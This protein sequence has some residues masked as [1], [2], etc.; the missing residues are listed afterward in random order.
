MKQLLL[1]LTATLVLTVAHGQTSFHTRYGSISHDKAN[2]VIQTQDGNFLVAG[3]TLGFGSS[4]N[5]FMMK[6]NASGAILWTKDYSGVNFDE[7]IDL[8]ELPGKELVMCG[9]TGSYGAGQTD[10]FVMKT[11]SLG[12]L[13]WSKSYGGF[14]QES[15]SKIST[16]GSGGFYIAGSGYTSFAFS[17]IIRLDSSGAII[18]SQVVNDFAG[19]VAMTPLASGGVILALT[20]NIGNQGF[21]L[22]KFSL[23]GALIWSNNYYP[24]PM[25]VGLSGGGFSIIEN[26]S[27][28]ILVNY[29]AS[30]TNTVAQASDNFVT[31]LN[32]NGTV[33]WN[34]SYGGT[35]SDYCKT[36]ANTNDG[37]IILFGM[38]NSAGNGD[39]DVC[40]I[41]LQSNGSFQWAK[42]YGTAW[43]DKISNGIQTADN[44][45]IFT[46]QTWTVG[47]AND[48]SKIHLVKTDALGNTS[49]NDISWNVTTINQAV[50]I[51]TASA[52]SN[53][54]LMDNPINWNFNN[55][56]LYTADICHYL[57]AES[58]SMNADN[59]RIYPNPFS[60]QTTFET[61][62]FL[63]NATLTLH[64]SFGQT[65]K[66][67]QNI[68]GQTVTLLRENLPSGL[69]FVRLTE[70]NKTVLAAK[71]VVVD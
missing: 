14:G 39:E 66:E 1:L 47:S 41:K 27:G 15:F 52:P 71:L 58:L 35:Y 55:R 40:L 13:I 3:H 18:W 57:S 11:D 44:G 42:A 63:H 50:S 19:K 34:K 10:G 38:T 8:I 26:G 51:T 36:I 56:Y 46:G 48:S 37:G 62:N 70:E 30:N 68:S 31:K 7:I 69:Y 67:I 53:I 61:D 28:E 43:A 60:S 9:T 4:G 12:N 2:K 65:V 6:V 59:W 21:S 5:A 17:L 49:C 24:T 33:I 20:Q 29:T 23:S 25:S 32:S 54:T 45:F 64:N 22:Y 16:D